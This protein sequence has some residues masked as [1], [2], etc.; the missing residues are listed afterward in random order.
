MRVAEVA[1]FVKR[2]SEMEGHRATCIQSVVPDP[3]GPLGVAVLKGPPG[4]ST[5][6]AVGRSPA[7]RAAS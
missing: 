5:S 1:Y 4:A 7:I 3:V 2:F 6:A